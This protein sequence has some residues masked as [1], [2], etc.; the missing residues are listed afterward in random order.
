MQR[1]NCE[2]FPCHSADQDCSLCFCP[3]YPCNDPRTGGRKLDDETWSCQ[4][5]LIIHRTDVAEMVLDCLMKG[6][7]LNC[8]W[9]KLEERL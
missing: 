4:S 3:F 7:S 1:L 2:R 5:C 9:M 6:E 8:V